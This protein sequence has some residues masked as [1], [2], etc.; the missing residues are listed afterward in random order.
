MAR[1]AP[2]LVCRLSVVHSGWIVGSA[3]NPKNKTPRDWDIIIPFENWAQASLLIPKNATPNTFGGWKCEDE[4][5]TID[6]W[7]GDISK[8]LNS[9]MVEWIWNIHL[10]IRFK[11]YD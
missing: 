11:R 10:D 3:A 5:A 4:G 9:S 6:V 2:A 7:P 8:V 1:K